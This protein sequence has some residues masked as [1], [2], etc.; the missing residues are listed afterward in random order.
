M[1]TSSYKH[2]YLQQSSLFIGAGRS[3]KAG[4]H[5]KSDKWCDNR[6]TDGT[7]CSQVIERQAKVTDD[8]SPD[9]R[10]SYRPV[11]NEQHRSSRVTND[12]FISGPSEGD[13][14]TETLELLSTLRDAKI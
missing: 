3:S 11:D 5:E 4:R 8:R 14:I 10:G 13:D 1:R 6:K 2:E 9:Y 12:K 7:S